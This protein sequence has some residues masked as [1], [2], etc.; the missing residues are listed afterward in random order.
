MGKYIF[1]SGIAIEVVYDTLLLAA[2]AIHVD[3]V[4]IQ[5]FTFPINDVVVK[6]RLLIVDGDGIAGR[7]IEYHDIIHFDFSES[8]NT[9]VFPLRPLDV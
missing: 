1:S 6:V 5:P 4:G 8:G 2:E 7:E 9:L 3:L